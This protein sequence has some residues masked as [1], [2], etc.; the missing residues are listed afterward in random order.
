MN[1][2][3][4]IDLPTKVIVG[5]G[6][7]KQ[8][9]DICRGMGY[10]HKILVLS[11][12]HTR[13]LVAETVLDSLREA[14]FDTTDMTVEGAPAEHV[15]D[16]IKRIS[17]SLVVGVGGGK[18]IDV[19]K[20]AS[21]RTGVPFVSVP[22]AA[23][24]DGIASPMA[25]LKSLGPISITARAPVVILADTEV[26]SRSPYRLT[27]SGCGDLIAKF[28]AVRDWKLAYR[29]RGEYYGDYAANLALMSAEVIARNSKVIRENSVEGIRTV[30]E[31]LISSGVAMCIAGS[32]RPCSGSE[33]LF[34]HAL[35]LIAPD[36]SLHGERCGVGTILMAYLH[37]MNWRRIKKVLEEIGAPTTADE[38]RVEPEH[39]VDAVVRARKLRP[40]RFTILEKRKITEEKALR[41]AKATGVIP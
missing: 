33:H 23:S 26:I 27:A 36:R 37:R 9:G 31:A 30:V 16:E 14:S 10:R 40:D 5:E 35:D 3:H 6:V 38:L 13:T 41:I 28:T 34:A 11:G 12:P 7:L 24:H 29:E 18:V 25:S 22:T 39:I 32:S 17:P 1:S 2:V 19:A 20:Y 21:Y 4:T 15:M 8:V